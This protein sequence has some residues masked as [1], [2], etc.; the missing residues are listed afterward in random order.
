MSDAN[1]DDDCRT[2]R[3]VRLWKCFYKFLQ[4]IDSIMAYVLF[5]SWMHIQYVCANETLTTHTVQKS[6][7]SNSFASYG[8]RRLENK[9]FELCNYLKYFDYIRKLKMLYYFPKF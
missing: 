3:K 4:Y 5:L 2:E 6:F 1:V 8:R 9:C 7:Y